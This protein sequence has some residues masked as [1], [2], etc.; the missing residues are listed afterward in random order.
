M[1]SDTLAIDHPGNPELIPDEAKRVRPECLFERH[2]HLPLSGERL[3]HTLGFV[4]G[5]RIERQRKPVAFILIGG[6]AVA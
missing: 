6:F 4:S 3:E 2:E 5:L 1:L